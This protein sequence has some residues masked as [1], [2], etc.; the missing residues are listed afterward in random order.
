MPLALIVWFCSKCKGSFGP[1]GDTLRER[2]AN[3][4]DNQR[5]LK[6]NRESAN[7]MFT[8]YQRPGVCYVHLNIAE[9]HPVDE[10]RTPVEHGV[11][12]KNTEMTRD[13]LDL[14]M[15]RMQLDNELWTCPM[16]IP[17]PRDMLNQSSDGTGRWHSIQE[18]QQ[19][20]RLVSFCNRPSDTLVPWKGNDPAVA[21]DAH[22]VQTLA[23]VSKR[24][25]SAPKVPL[26]VSC[27]PGESVGFVLG[28]RLRLT[29]CNVASCGKPRRE[30]RNECEFTI[31]EDIFGV[32]LSR[33]K[34]NLS[35]LTSLV[36]NPSF[37]FAT[38]GL[39]L[40]DF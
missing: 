1:H 30:W 38:G 19:Q 2:L 37:F 12:I 29:G 31:D 25:P 17:G 26:L 14:L 20:C 23:M 40:E 21:K 35:W 36:T 32:H 33:N 8:W 24:S 3:I 39:H 18:R 6:G 4:L 10:N 9:F 7:C 5:T 15:P 13:G 34:K 16:S 22:L 28:E 11:L 27:G